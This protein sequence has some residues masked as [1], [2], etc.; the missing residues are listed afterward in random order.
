MP[1]TTTCPVDYLSQCCGSLICVDHRNVICDRPRL[2]GL[3]VE[4]ANL[5]FWDH[6]NATGVGMSVPSFMYFPKFLMK[7]R[8][9]K[10]NSNQCLLEEVSFQRKIVTDI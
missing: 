7:M 4:K 1:Y 2:L 6:L 5:W 8:C 9:Q 3:R 10:L